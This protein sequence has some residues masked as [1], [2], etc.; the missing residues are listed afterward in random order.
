M[1]EAI[2][3]ITTPHKRGA[4]FTL[5]DVIQFVD[6]AHTLGFADDTEIEDGYLYLSKVVEGCDI[7]ECGDHV[8]GDYKF[9]VL[10]PMHDH[11][12]DEP[13]QEELPYATYDYL[14][15]DRT[16]RAARCVVGEAMTHL[17]ECPMLDV[18]PYIDEDWDKGTC[19]CDRLHACEQRVRSER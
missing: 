13:V 12:E 14:S 6:D 10:V 19:I 9:D 5:A 8:Y 17:P 7:V 15:Q 18:L 1:I 4:I 16:R 2:L 11:P 3:S